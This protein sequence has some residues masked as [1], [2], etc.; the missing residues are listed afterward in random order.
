MVLTQMSHL[1]RSFYVC[2]RPLGPSGDKERGTEWRC[3][4]FIWSSDWTKPSQ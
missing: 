4:T 1:G 3:G 2:A